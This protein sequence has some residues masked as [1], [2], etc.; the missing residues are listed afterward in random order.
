MIVMPIVTIGKG[1][2]ADRCPAALP[3]IA[4]TEGLR[5]WFG[6]HLL[7]EGG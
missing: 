6:T 5:V 2:S 7:P 4:L 3:T 1:I